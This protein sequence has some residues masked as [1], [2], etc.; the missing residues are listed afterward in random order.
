VANAAARALYDDL[1]FSVVDE[2]AYR[3]R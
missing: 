2:Y 3:E 1:G